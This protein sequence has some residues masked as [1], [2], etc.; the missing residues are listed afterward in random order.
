MWNALLLLSINIFGINFLVVFTLVDGTKKGVLITLL[1][2]MLLLLLL[3]LLLLFLS[4]DDELT[5]GCNDDDVFEPNCAAVKGPWFWRFRTDSKK[6]LAS[7]NIGANIP[8]SMFTNCQL[9][10]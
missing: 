9:L 10:C 6:F 5:T 3:L 8:C 1:I 7:P 4:L 2:P